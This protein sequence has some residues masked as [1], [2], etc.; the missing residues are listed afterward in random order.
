MDVETVRAQAEAFCDA[1]V[2]GDVERASG[3]MSKELRQHL[4]EVGAGSPQGR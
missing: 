1:L 4:G 3:D 2:A